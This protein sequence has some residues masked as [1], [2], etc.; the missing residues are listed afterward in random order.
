MYA[1]IGHVMVTAVTTLVVLSAVYSMHK[2][3]GKGRGVD[4]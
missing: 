3:R 4:F 2:E 1:A